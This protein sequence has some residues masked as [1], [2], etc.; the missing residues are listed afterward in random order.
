MPFPEA[1]RAAVSMTSSLF[2]QLGPRLEW[3]KGELL[4]LH[5][6]DT[7]LEPVLG[8][9]MED[10]T[11][12][13][14]PGLHRYASPAGWPPLWTA[15]VDRVSAQPG[16]DWVDR[17][18]LLVTA[19]CTGALAAT[20]G[21]ILDPGDEVLLCSPYWPLIRGIVQSR[22]ATPVDVP[23]MLQGHDADAVVAGLEAAITPRTAAIYVN[24]PNNPTGV[25]LP[26]TTLEAIA[27]LARRRGLW[28]LSDEVYEHYA[29]A[30]PW[31]PMAS[32]APERTVATHSFSKAYGH[33]GN[34]CG[35]LVGP[36]AVVRQARRIATHL[37]YNPPT[38]AQAAALA[39]L[40]GGDSWL[41]QARAAYLEEAVH[42]ADRLGVPRPQGGTFLFLDVAEHLDDRGLLGFLEDCV[43]RG[44]VLAPGP[45]FGQHWQSHVRLCFT[46]EPPEKVRR[47]VEI[48]AEL[49]GR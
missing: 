41:S 4:A 39:A 45:S 1:S 31:I 5:V 40:E 28:I 48:L 10:L 16:M 47:G 24:S 32:L 13:D 29:F 35:W 8:S 9:R 14:H 21:A 26:R 11:T 37:I 6:G 34:R 15:L 18:H 25:L 42:A 49:I 30:G 44:L 27:E 33:A 12:R 3:F 36:E 2:G 19:G 46:C 22:G 20:V 43:D 17:G 38:P 23:V 7:W